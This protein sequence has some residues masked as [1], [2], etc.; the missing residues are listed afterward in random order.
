MIEAI[1]L[2]YSQ[3][4]ENNKEVI[5][6]VLKKYL[7]A[8]HRVLEIGSGTGQHAMHFAANLPAIVWQ[9]ADQD[10]Y[11][12]AIRYRVEQAQL[13]NLLPPLS[14]EAT[15][16]NWQGVNADS[17]FSANTAHIMPWLA[18]C[19]MFSGIGSTI[20]DGGLF[21]LYGPFNR[22][23][24]FTSESNSAFHQS[25]Q[26][27]NPQMGIRDDTD[28]IELGQKCGLFLQQD[29]PMPANN[30]ILIWCNSPNHS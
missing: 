16:F 6:D 7:P 27:Q 15:T 3:A 12:P 22:Q 8:G 28:L 26:H 25:L 19:A 24:R 2:P 13:D 18:V 10:Q 23:G 17:F 9:C 21:I 29:I 14:L 1:N 5:L 11:H 20:A 30:R 4:C